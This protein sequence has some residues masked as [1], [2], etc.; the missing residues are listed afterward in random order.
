MKRFIIA[1]HLV[2]TQLYLKMCMKLTFGGGA[3]CFYA[4]MHE[5]TSEPPLGL[6]LCNAEVHETNSEPP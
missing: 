6:F 2:L 5:T 4:N 3:G 1:E